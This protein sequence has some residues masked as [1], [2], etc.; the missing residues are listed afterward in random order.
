MLAAS[1]ILLT[2]D[3]AVEGLSDNFSRPTLRTVAPKINNVVIVIIPV[4]NDH[5]SLQLHTYIHPRA[6]GVLQAI[7]PTIIIYHICLPALSLNTLFF[8]LGQ[9]EIDN[10]KKATQPVLLSVGRPRSS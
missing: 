5:W 4:R 1:P 8:V 9:I 7:I 10:K 3:V 2:E 6:Y